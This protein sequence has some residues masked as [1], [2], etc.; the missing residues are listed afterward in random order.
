MLG[1]SCTVVYVCAVHRKWLDTKV[2]YK[3]HIGNTLQILT[4]HFYFVE[5]MIVR[6]R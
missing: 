6:W 2:Q 5:M 1:G 3:V 4:W